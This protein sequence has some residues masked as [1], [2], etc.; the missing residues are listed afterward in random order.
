MKNAIKEELMNIALVGYGKMGH[1]IENIAINKGFSVIATIDSFAQD[2]THKVTDQ[3]ELEKAIKECSPDVIIEFTHPD[4]VMENIKTL[5]PLGIPIVV[6]TTGWSNKITEVQ[7]LADN[8][9][10]AL[11]Y[12]SNYS[13]G[14]NMFYRIVEEAAKLMSNYEDYDVALWEAHHTQ[15]ADS[16]SGTALDLAKAVMRGNNKKTETI[17]DAFHEKPQSH[18]LHVSST[19]V[20]SVPGTHTVFFDSM[21]D[22]IELTHTARNREGFALGAVLA[23]KWICEGIANKTLKKGCLYTMNDMLK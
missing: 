12:A 2:A 22:T 5:L 17:I 14:V 16:P 13:I 15:K 4:S 11:F 8:N 18:Q 3:S 20:G 19:R 7:E 1:I 6:G 9:S 21:A 10:N 23:A